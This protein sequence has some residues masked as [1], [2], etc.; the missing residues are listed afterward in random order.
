MTTQEAHTDTHESAAARH[1]LADNLRAKGRLR[2]DRVT[3]AFRTVPRHRFAPEATISEAYADDV[4]RTKK[5]EHGE[6][7]SSISAPWLQAEMLEQSGLGP[8][9]RALEI[10]SGGYNAA[11]LADIVG[12]TG[13][14]VSIDIDPFVTDRARRF[15]KDTGYDDRVTVLEAD[16]AHAA[17]DHAPPGGFDAILVTAE[18]ADLPPTWAEQLAP[19]GRLVV[20]LRFRGMS[21][22]WCFEHENGQL[23]SRRHTYCGFVRMQGEAASSER[24]I[25][26]D[27]EPRVQLTIDENQHANHDALQKAFAGPRHEV[28][29]GVPLAREEPALP[30]LDMW[31]AGDQTPFGLFHASNQAHEEG[32]TAWVLDAGTAATW[33]RDSFAY[34]ALRRTPP[35]GTRQVKRRSASPPTDQTVNSWPSISPPA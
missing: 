32:L 16:G 25:R 19:A 21:R 14:V 3:R 26:F 27:C 15:L 2:S 6:T 18:A 1:S 24:H 33:T 20:P 17:G 29:P 5:N 9:M 8:G 7:L 28:W 30:V 4:V 11:L 12:P 13:H 34:V 10:G 31:L 35:S 22:A 23:I